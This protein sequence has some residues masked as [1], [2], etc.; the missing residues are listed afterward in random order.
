ME[1]KAQRRIAA[2]IMKC[3]ESR[4]WMDPARLGD[5]SQAITTQ[6][7][8]RLVKD[9]VVRKKPKQGVSKARVRHTA[10]QKRKGRR[11]GK[12][13]RKGALG[14]R[15]SRKNSWM[16][17]IRGQ[18]SLAKNLLKEGKIDKK[19]YKDVYRKAGGGFFRSRAHLMQYAGVT[20]EIK[21][22]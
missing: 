2:K 17:M 18:R 9:G 21:N 10:Q 14:S 6:D 11:K 19:V 16:N 8:R 7:V 1:L 3:G 22:E 15:H 12:G 20:T 4:V 5:I 13:S